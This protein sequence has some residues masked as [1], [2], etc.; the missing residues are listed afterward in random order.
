[1]TG[2]LA[3]VLYMCDWE[4][5]HCIAC[6]TGRLAIVVIMIIIIIVMM[7]MM[8]SVFLKRLSM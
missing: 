1:M 6:V 4:A 3:T 7:I 5:S 2:K 8:T